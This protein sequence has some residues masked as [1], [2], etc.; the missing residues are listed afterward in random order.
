MSFSVDD[1]EKELADIL[2]CAAIDANI[3]C[4]KRK[5]GNTSNQSKKVQNKCVSKPWFN[6]ECKKLK[7]K[8]K[9]LGKLSKKDPFNNQHRYK[10]L[11]LRKKYKSVIRKNKAS[12]NKNIWSK[13]EGTKNNN[14]KEFW[15]LLED[16]KGLDNKQKQSSITMDEWVKHFTVLLN[17]TITPNLT[18][19]DEI[20]D[21]LMKNRNNIFNKLN[22][23]INVSEI[24]EAIKSLKL[25]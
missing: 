5:P 17:K 6:D 15:K 24:M 9:T 14:P 23:S 13:L 2:S 16:L 22:F 8:C 4:I 1:A 21:Y 19:N 11:S 3:K 25:K 18:L 7:E 20:D 10:I 12:F